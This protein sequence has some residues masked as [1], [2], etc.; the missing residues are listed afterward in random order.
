MLHEQRLLL[1]T[2]LLRTLLEPIMYGP[3]CSTVDKAC[4]SSLQIVLHVAKLGSMTL[5]LVMPGVV[6]SFTIL[7]V[8]LLLVHI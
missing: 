1:Q 2:P 3:R 8:L 4:R 7:T 5:L 6:C